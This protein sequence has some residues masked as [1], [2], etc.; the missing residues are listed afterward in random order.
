M[1]GN[2]RARSIEALRGA[3]AELSGAELENVSQAI[4]VLERLSEILLDHTG[5]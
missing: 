1:L 4:P 2:L 5:R 3:L